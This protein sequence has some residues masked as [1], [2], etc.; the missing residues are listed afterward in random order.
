MGKFDDFRNKNSKYISLGYGEKATVQ[1]KGPESA[2]ECVNKFGSP[3]MLFTFG[4]RFGDKQ[5]T[6]TNSSV[7]AQFENYNEGD[8]IV[9]CR[10]LKDEK[11]GLAVYKAGEEAPF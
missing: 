8:E 4:T 2:V 9:L 5:Y 10:N 6:I 11:P 7:I 1:Y 3:G